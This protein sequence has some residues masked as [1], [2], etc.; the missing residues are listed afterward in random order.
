[1]RDRLKEAG[2]N[3]QVLAPTNA[4]ARFAGGTTVHAFLNKMSNS[5]H[6]FSGVILIDEVSMLSLGLVGVLDQLRAGDCRI[7]SFYVFNN[8][9]LWV[10][11]GEERT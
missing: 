9:H 2:L 1:M 6:S 5:R 10:T 3:T 11:V 4:A 7:I 8:Y